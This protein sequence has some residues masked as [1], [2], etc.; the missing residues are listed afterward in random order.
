[1]V[2]PNWFYFPSRTVRNPDRG[3][4]AA[5]RRPPH[6]RAGHRKPT[7]ALEKTYRALPPPRV[8]IAVGAC[9]ISGG[10][11]LDHLGAHN[12]AAGIVP[13]DLFTSGC[14]PH[15]LTILGGLLRITSL[16]A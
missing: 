10:P 14:P 7:L 15:P 11:Y 8:V 1:M 13:V 6:H 2:I 16:E 9:A 3:L 12:G 5:C 4:P